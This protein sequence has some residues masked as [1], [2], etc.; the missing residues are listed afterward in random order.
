MM[1]TTHLVSIVSGV[2]KIAGPIK[3]AIAVL[4]G[5][6]GNIV[7]SEEGQTRG[8]L[9]VAFAFCWLGG[10]FGGQGF[11]KSPVPDIYTT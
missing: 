2:V 7:V 4:H 10:S 11:P 1:Q 9:G 5:L 6:I 8:A 3:R